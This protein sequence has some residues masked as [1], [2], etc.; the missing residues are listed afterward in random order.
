MIWSDNPVADA[1]LYLWEEA[2]AIEKLP[3]CSECGDPIYGDP[4]YDS[5]GNAVCEDCLNDNYRREND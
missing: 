4:N 5:W 1:E 3:K 2:K